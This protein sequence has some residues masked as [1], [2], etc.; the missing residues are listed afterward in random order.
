MKGKKGQLAGLQGVIA[1]LLVV[2]VVIAAGFFVLQEFF[3]Q[4]EFSDTSGSATLE[5]VTKTQYVAGHDLDGASKSGANSF[6]ITQV[7]NKTD[8]TV[9]AAGNYTV[10]DDGTFTNTSAD[11]PYD[12]NVSY[13]YLYGEASWE[14]M[15]NT[16]DAMSTI[17]SLL[18]LIIIIILLVGVVLAVLFSSLPMR[19]SGA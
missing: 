17:P 19:M 12:W 14:G 4:D 10:T 2:A 1:T 11:M 7:K 9:I 6:S 16:L 3:E 15:N 5:L 13:S 18:P 8:G